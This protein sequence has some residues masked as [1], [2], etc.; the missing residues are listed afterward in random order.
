MKK[1]LVSSI[2]SGAAVR[3]RSR[4]QPAT[5]PSGSSCSSQVRISAGIARLSATDGFS[6]KGVTMIGSPLAGIS[7]AVSRSDP[8]PAD[9]GKI[10]EA[11]A[12]LDQ[13]RAEAVASHQSARAG[14]ADEAFG[15]RNRGREID[16]C[17]GAEPRRDPGR[18]TERG[19]SAHQRAPTDPKLL[20]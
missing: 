4:S 11:R 2:P 16:R 20:H 18:S 17:R 3:R 8:A 14:K 10:I 13:D 15:G 1:R 12:G 6:K 19:A 5:S 9:P 7:A